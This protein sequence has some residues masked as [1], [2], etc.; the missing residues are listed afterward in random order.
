[1]LEF[2][3][4]LVA[5][6]FGEVLFQGILELLAEFGW[7]SLENSLRSAKSA[8]PFYAACGL[9]ILGASLGL[10]TA[11]LLPDPLF[12][13]RP[14]PGISLILAPL[15]AGFCMHLLG[16]WRRKKGG[17]PTCLATFWGGASFAFG[18]ALVRW[19]ITT[20]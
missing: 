13:H 12:H 10:G 9:G 11:L 14:V 6:I 17:N 15:G 3:F 1:M 2:V 8:N 18:M 5:E 19:L 16:A 4:E 7:S 20:H